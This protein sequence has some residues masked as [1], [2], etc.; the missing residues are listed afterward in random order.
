VEREGLLLIQKFSLH[1]PVKLL[2]LL[3]LRLYSEPSLIDISFFVDCEICSPLPLLA[4]N[5]S[6]Y[7]AVRF[8]VSFVLSID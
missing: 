1:W 2:L 5:K 4:N 6:N 3:L 7:G 8:C